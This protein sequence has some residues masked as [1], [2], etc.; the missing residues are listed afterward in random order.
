M[1]RILLYIEV[2]FEK[3]GSAVGGKHWV[4]SVELEASRRQPLPFPTLGDIPP[5]GTASANHPGIAMSFR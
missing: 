2:E 5:Y 4:K 3:L 1:I